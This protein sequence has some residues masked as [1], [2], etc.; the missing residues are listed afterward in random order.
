MEGAPLKPLRTP[1]ITRDTHD[2]TD[3]V[4][5]DREEDEYDQDEVDGFIACKACRTG[6]VSAALTSE[7]SPW[8]EL[9][10]VTSGSRETVCGLYDLWRT[11]QWCAFPHPDCQRRQ[12]S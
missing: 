11:K 4:E 7:F 1:M 3:H 2:T 6:C 12:C 8:V 10:M 9:E 5:E